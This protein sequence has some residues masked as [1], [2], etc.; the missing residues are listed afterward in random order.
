[1]L[2]K[3]PPEVCALIFDFA[4]RDGRTGLSLSHV[5]RYIRNTS[6]LAR[7][8]SIVLSGPAQIIAFAQFAEHT[9]IKLKTRYLF[10]NGQE[11]EQ[12][13]E[14]MVHE[15]YAGT[16]KARIEYRNL[17]R[18]RFLLPGDE[19]LREAEEAVARECT[20]A[21]ILL[22]MEGASAVES[23]LRTV[24]P[25][26][27]VLDISLNKYVAKMLLN[28]MSLPCLVDLTTRCGFPLCPSGVPGL[29]P[30]HSLRYLHIVD[31]ARNWVCVEGFFRN[32][33]SYFAPSLTYLR[34]SELY[35]DEVVIK[36]LECALG[37]SEDSDF[38]T[39]LPPTLERV[40]I[41]PAVAPQHNC[42][43]PC[44]VCVELQDYQD[45][46]RFARR[47][48]QKDAR[49]KLMK[50]NSIRVEGFQ[51]WLDKN[52]KAVSGWDTSDLDLDSEEGETE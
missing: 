7:Y 35:E 24:G 37:H 20:N 42:S 31:S 46:V 4:C 9:R 44:D 32:G 14:R 16:R 25:T 8:T 52:V 28:P 40:V 33:I 2:D 11:S 39:Q 36:D 13:L 23:I 19:K 51:E 10:I 6:E 18:N 15:A 22:G 26:L 1:M 21:D 29:E 41:R 45:L 27:E 3:L 34:L 43:P 50:A 17:A 12:E 38:V 30:T 48:H 49:V 5:S 47:L